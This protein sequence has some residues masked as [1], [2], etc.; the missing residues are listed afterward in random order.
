MH[1]AQYSVGIVVGGNYTRD[2]A[3]DDALVTVAKL[4]P[5]SLAG[6][7]YTVNQASAGSVASDAGKRTNFGF[8]VK[9]VKSGANFQG[10]VT[11]IVQSGGRTYQVKSN[12]I[13]SLVTKVATGTAP[14][15]GSFSGKANITDIT[16]PSAPLA[17][18]V[19]A[20]LQVTLTDR[21]EPGSSDTI[22]ITVWGKNGKL[23]FSNN[24]SGTKT[25]EQTIG[26]GNLAVR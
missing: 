21:G 7:G 25:V 2:S 15:T 8:S 1:G 12:A 6:G 16:N 23:W 22:G 20:T 19:N 10:S 17:V 9:N 13:G 4:I 18:E 26:G 24:W 14:G 3:G 5:G 11:V